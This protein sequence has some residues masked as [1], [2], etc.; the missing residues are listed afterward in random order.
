MRIQVVHCHPLVT[1]YNHALYQAIV[2]TLRT[3]GHEVVATDLYRE[4]FQPAMTERERQTYMEEDYDYSAVAG[5]AETL[6][7]VDGVILCFPHWWFSMPAMLKGWVDR[8]WGPSIAFDYDPKDK[9]LEPALRNIK[10]FGVVTSYGSPWWIVN[11][12][13]G[14]AGKKVLMRGMKPLCAKGVRSFYMAHY[15]MDHST[16]QSREA[17]LAKV[18]ARVARL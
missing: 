7:S 4:G 15:N 11:L 17:F 2:E 3:N 9:H 12:F 16:P 6:K 18:R 14:N 1:G 8:V 5:Y 13:A 10:L